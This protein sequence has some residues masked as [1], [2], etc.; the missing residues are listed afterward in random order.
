LVKLQ[1]FL[2]GLQRS[3]SGTSQ[4][5]EPDYSPNSVID[6]TRLIGGTSRQEDKKKRKRKNKD[7]EENSEETFKSETFLQIQQSLK[8]SHF[9]DRDLIICNLI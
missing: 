2:A 7:T 3:A 6:L 5:S 8:L 9:T 4:D 1:Q